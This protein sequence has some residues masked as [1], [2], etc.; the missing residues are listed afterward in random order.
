MATILETPITPLSEGLKTKALMTETAGPSVG[1][2]IIP[3]AI[4]TAQMVGATFEQ[5]NAKRQA[6]EFAQLIASGLSGMQAAIEKAK[7]EGRDVTRIRDP[8][9]Y[10]DS[11]ENTE[12]WWNQYIAE[13]E[14]Q[15]KEKAGIEGFS[16]IAG[17]QVEKGL[18]T[19]V[20]AG[21]A[22]PEEAGKQVKEMREREERLKFLTPG[23][24]AKMEAME[25]ITPTD[26]K[27]D[28]FVPAGEEISTNL[29]RAGLKTK[30]PEK[31]RPAFQSA[32]S[33]LEIPESILIGISARESSFNPRA[34][35]PDPD[36]TATGLTQPIRSTAQANLDD[37]I[38][39]G[40]IPAGTK[41]EKAVLDPEMNLIIGGL[42]FKRNLKKFDGDVMKALLAH[43]IGPG[44]VDDFLKTGK[45]INPQTKKD[46]TND[47]NDWIDDVSIAAFGK[48]MMTKRAPLATVDFTDK[49]SLQGE[50]QRIAANAEYAAST[51]G[52]EVLNQLN[53]QLDRIIKS[54]KEGKGAAKKAKQAES[55]GQ[56]LDILLSLAGGVEPSGF[57]K[58]TFKNLLAY[59][60]IDA[61]TAQF[62]DFKGLL[63][64][65][66]SKAIGGES[67]RL[68]NQDREMAMKALPGATDSEQ[69]RQTKIK[70]FS[71]LAENLR[72]DTLTAEEKA[73]ALRDVLREV[74][75][76]QTD[77]DDKIVYQLKDLPSDATDDMIKNFLVANSEEPSAGNVAAVRAK[78]GAKKQ[79][80]PAEKVKPI[81]AL[82]PEAPP[83][84]PGGFRLPAG[85]IGEQ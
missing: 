54:E 72:D 27:I 59:F 32:A 76:N 84:E 85:P 50:I 18:G 80:A 8:K 37:A 78:I 47:I 28:A 56:T 35:N 82:T 70:I 21:L 20:G 6:M 61:E 2:D 49:E 14:R 52:K 7:E 1:P 46:E 13:M 66:I 67:G 40:L 22:K 68:T 43:R 12:A 42:E 10:V 26:I 63:A 79:M 41:V 57:L 19:L 39:Q 33:K 74:I 77:K 36:S 64:T 45:F 17:G 4:G 34:K 30:I 9:L 55:I 71:K 25:T 3:R 24:G 11:R 16:Q 62:N 75:A 48:P 31:I 23:G 58:G 69:I 51:E 81:K 44:A 5:E 60:R 73:D 53:K 83:A 38:E 15:D 29:R 65:Q